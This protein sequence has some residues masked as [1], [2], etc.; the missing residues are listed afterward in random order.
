MEE[1]FL[2]AT[3]YHILLAMS[4]ADEQKESRLLVTKSTDSIIEFLDAVSNDKNFPF[5]K[6]S[7]YKGRND[8]AQVPPLKGIFLGR[9]DSY[10]RIHKENIEKFNK[11]EN[12]EGHRTYIFHDI[13]P[14]YQYIAYRN[15]SLG[16]FNIMIEE[17]LRMYRDYETER[18][19]LKRI[20]AK[21]F[22]GSWYKWE[23][24]LAKS[25]YIDQIKC[26]YPNLMPERNV[27]TEQLDKEIFSDITVEERDNLPEDSTL[28]IAPISDSFK[29]QEEKEKFI[30]SLKKVSG[31][32]KVVVKYHPKEE[33]RYLCHLTDKEL[34]RSRPLELT[35]VTSRNTPQEVVGSISTALYTAELYYEDVE[36]IS[37]AGT[38]ELGQRSKETEKEI[39]KL[40]QMGIKIK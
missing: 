20:L 22:V 14:I 17:G 32:S 40:C 6:C 33:N 30:D 26:F 39:D 31:G 34:D 25:G 4:I 38:L 8:K 27:D 29:S 16:G 11:E 18:S 5:D 13:L 7:V 24:N 10:F 1:T 3:P 15:K 2:T 28:V 19:F 21:M 35:Y 12:L 37:L 23:N 9:E 36:V